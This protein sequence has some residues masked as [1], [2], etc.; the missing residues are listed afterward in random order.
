MLDISN[1]Q[2]K[3]K[4]SFFLCISAQSIFLCEILI[5]IKTEMLL[6]LSEGSFKRAQL[7]PDSYSTEMK[8]KID[9]NDDDDR[10][11]DH[12]DDRSQLLPNRHRGS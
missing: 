9:S 2:S 10:R 6:V 8:I 11:G 1:I 12:N 5:K 4:K 3:K 7:M